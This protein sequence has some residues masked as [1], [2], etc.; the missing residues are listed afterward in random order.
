ME[1]CHTSHSRSVRQYPFAIKEP[2]S[3]ILTT[4]DMSQQTL[5][6]AVCVF[7]LMV[8]TQSLI[9][10]SD[11]RCYLKSCEISLAARDNSAIASENLPVMENK[12][13]AT[14]ADCA[15]VA[16]ENITT[17]VQISQ[18]GVLAGIVNLTE[19]TIGNINSIKGELMSEISQRCR[20]RFHFAD[21]KCK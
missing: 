6:L 14:V 15:S 9:T 17:G 7:L 4:M 8:Q 18:E 16:Q 11:P 21:L 12:I 10:N 2:L 19:S 13:Q 5:Y 20:P 1:T 3:D